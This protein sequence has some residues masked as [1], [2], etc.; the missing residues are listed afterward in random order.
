MK[1]NAVTAVSVPRERS[2]IMYK[3]NPASYSSVFVLPTQIAD[4]HLRM[5]GKAQLKVLLWLYRNPSVTPD[6]DVIARDTERD[7]FMTAQQAMEYGL[8]D[9]VIER[10]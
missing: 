4:K 5:A 7:N 10:R 6:I 8:I 9:K 2:K 3:I 1:Q